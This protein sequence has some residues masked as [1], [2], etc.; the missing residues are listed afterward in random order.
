MRPVL[1]DLTSIAAAPYRTGIQ[2]VERE[3]IR[4]WPGPRP[5]AP[6]IF[7]AQSE[8]MLALPE[9]SLDILKE[10]RGS[11]EEERERLEAIRKQ[12]RPLDPAALD[13]GILNPEVFWEQPRAEFYRKHCSAGGR[14]AWIVYDFFPVL[15]PENYPSGT[16]RGCMY[17]YRALR[18]VPHTIFISLRTRS[19]F[20]QRIMRGTATPGPAIPLGGDAL[21]T[22][23]Q[24]FSPDRTTFLVIGTI[25]RRKRAD[26]VIEA[27]RLH[28]ARGGRARLV[29]VGRVDDAA[30]S[31]QRLIRLL[32]PHPRFKFAGPLSD[33][34][35]RQM[36]GS[37]RATIYNTRE[38]GFGIPPYES[39]CAGVPVFARRGLPSLAMLA[40]GG[41]IELDAADGPD[42][43]A[44]AV[45]RM[46]DDAE[47]ARLW[48]EAAA[49]SVPTWRDFA[50]QT[51]SYVQE[52]AL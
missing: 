8:S 28:W 35:L 50:E 10:G 3:L 32:E 43:I 47:A 33:D 4:H 14:S 1:L 17:Y 30:Q 40:P 36:L 11:F 13:D 52:E 37:A 15:R 39:L 38:E 49:L 2:R 22:P 18:A 9:G 26:E 16:A 42:E 12:A 24:F 34:A 5:L 45:D 41:R 6:V 31:E 23:R 21:G 44:A 7:D 51:A 29:L 20:A 19:E 27:F 46:M 48:S 25:E